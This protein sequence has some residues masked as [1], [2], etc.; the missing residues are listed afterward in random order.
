MGKCGFL[1]VFIT[2]SYNVAGQST[3]DVTCPAADTS[4]ACE[5][6]RQLDEIWVDMNKSSSALVDDVMEAPKKAEEMGC[7]DQLKQ[8]DLSVV[9]V[10]PRSIWSTVYAALKDRIVNRACTAI[11]DAV[12]EQTA[13]LNN[14]LEAPM[15]L[16][17][18]AIQQ[19]GTGNGLDNFTRTRVRI[20]DEDARREVVRDTLGVYP[21]I[22]SQSDTD[23]KIREDRETRV[24]TSDRERRT[25]EQEDLERVLDFNR[26]WKKDTDGDSNDG[27]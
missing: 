19:S 25:A 27:N 1:L 21:T 24:G 9:T 7:L 3:N 18:V 5:Q 2:A 16:G 15:G 6:R 13:R 20:T 12:N 26:L 17:S 8:I 11:N 4:I 22:Q 23:I 10:D 14:R